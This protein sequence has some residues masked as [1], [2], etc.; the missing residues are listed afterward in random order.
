MSTISLEICANSLQSA[1]EG[2]KGGAD[3]VEL[4]NNLLEGGTTPSMAQIELTRKFLE[5]DLNVII[6]PRGG[7]FLYNDLEFEI[8][9]QDIHYCGKAGCD[10]IVFGIL[11]KQGNVDKI[12]CQ[13][14][15][16]IA[17]EYNMSTTFHRAFDRCTDLI[18]SLEEIITL[19]C[20]RIL[21]SGGKE[22]AFQGKDSI[23]NLIE[24]AGERIIIMPGG[25]INEENIIPLIEYTGLK[26]FHGSFQSKFAGNMEY[27][28]DSFGQYS[29]EN[30]LLL[31]DQNR[32]RNIL[33]KVSD[34]KAFA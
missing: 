32:V 11:T 9:K 10:G 15:V 30:T 27:I 25:G 28:P 13:E 31:T 7:N 21:T 22:T 8:M 12:R 5:I 20:T 6:R 19:G 33:N 18:I 34:Y 14:L 24:Q 23:R 16:N 26:E 1:I 29:T 3:R 4:C 17:Q 2:Q